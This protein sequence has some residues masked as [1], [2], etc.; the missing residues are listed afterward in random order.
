MLHHRC[1]R[2]RGW[3]ARRKGRGPG[4]CGACSYASPF[5]RSQKQTLVTFG[6]TTDINRLQIHFSLSFGHVGRIWNVW[7]Y[8]MSSICLHYL[9]IHWRVHDFNVLCVF[10]V[11]A[12]H[13]WLRRHKPR[14]TAET[15]SEFSMN[16]GLE[17]GRPSFKYINYFRSVIAEFEIELTWHQ[18]FG[19]VGFECVH[20][21]LTLV[22]L[23]Q[24]V[25]VPGSFGVQAF[26]EC[27]SSFCSARQFP[28]A[29]SRGFVEN[30]TLQSTDIPFRWF[31]WRTF[32]S[33]TGT[34]TSKNGGSSV[35]QHLAGEVECIGRFQEQCVL[36][37]LY[38]NVRN[39]NETE[40]SQ[41][42]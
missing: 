9:F 26:L 14:K 24:G 1:S 5:S 40:G 16:C 22:K 3:H 27:S 42:I 20:F 33:H 2:E 18:H 25:P 41:R 8:R 11:F 39:F 32:G 30:L 7:W 4:R 29:E 35:Q 36:S 15:S 10:H 23:S 21:K 37:S 38:C 28:T 19:Y 13:V 31:S 17:V 34:R 6:Y 12:L